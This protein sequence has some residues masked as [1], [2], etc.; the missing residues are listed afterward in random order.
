MCLARALLK[1][2]KILIMDEATAAVDYETDALIQKTIRSEFSY[3]TVLTIAHRVHTIM[4]YD[5]V[6]VLD[7]VAATMLYSSSTLIQH[8]LNQQGKILEFG[9]PSALLTIPNGAFASMVA[10][11]GL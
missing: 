3:C 6:M 8:S 11:S 4:D 9:T 5:R 2:A 1:K 7:K 10:K